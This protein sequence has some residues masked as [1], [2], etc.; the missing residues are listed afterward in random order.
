MQ[1]IPYS[2]ILQWYQ[3]EYSQQQSESVYGS[4]KEHLIK[5]FKVLESCKNL[6][7]VLELGCGDGANVIA[8]AERGY[9]VTGIDIA[10]EEAVLYRASQKSL[11]TVK[12]IT[13]DITSYPFDKEFYDCVLCA[14]VFHLLN[15][16]Q[17]EV[18]ARKA[19]RAVS[20][21]GLICLDV[22]TNMKRVFRDSGEEFTFTGLANWSAHQAKEFFT[23]LFSDWSVLDMFSFHK[24]ADWPVKPG[25]YPIAPY[26]WSADYVCVIAKHP[27]A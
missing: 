7:T 15:A 21:G 17:I 14:G 1:E 12:F 2:K 8:L 19:K 4:L 9:H 24:E 22:A 18:V 6:T 11:D 23:N 27:T 3:E 10:G 25:N 20:Q 13:A 26:H 5:F 16:E